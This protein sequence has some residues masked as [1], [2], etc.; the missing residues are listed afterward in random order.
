MSAALLR[1]NLGSPDEPGTTNQHTESSWRRKSS[2]HVDAG[3]TT[4]M[5]MMMMLLS[6]PFHIRLFFISDACKQTRTHSRTDTRRQMLFTP[7]GQPHCYLFARRFGRMCNI[8]SHE[9]YILQNLN[10][11]AHYCIAF[12]LIRAALDQHFCTR[13]VTSW[14]HL[15]RACVRVL[16]PQ[17]TAHRL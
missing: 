7:S 2:S 1:T 16:F 8:L 9:D 13:V 11:L 17:H 15:W 5:L 14:A 12:S 3:S 10:G 4:A 6:E